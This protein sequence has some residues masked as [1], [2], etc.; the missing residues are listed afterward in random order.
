MIN[1][2]HIESEIVVSQPSPRPLKR[3]LGMFFWTLVLAAVIGTVGAIYVT[4]YP[5]AQSIPAAADQQPGKVLSYGGPNDVYFNPK[6][7]KAGDK[8]SICFD[9]VVWHKICKSELIYHVTCYKHAMGAPD[10][11]VELGRTDF[12][13]YAI[14]VPRETGPV[15]RKCRSF[16]IPS[17]CQPGPISH[18]AF[19]RH[20]CAGPDGKTQLSYTP[21]P[22]FSGTVD[23]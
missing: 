7:F 20:E 15:G 19:A 11:V 8:V 1:G 14:S 6:N 23:P 3:G 18:S 5:V 16:A 4:T 21:V 10:G 2:K 9:G 13:V 12:P 22:D 17:D